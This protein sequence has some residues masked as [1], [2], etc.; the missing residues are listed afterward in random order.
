MWINDA[1]IHHANFEMKKNMYKREQKEIRMQLVRA[2]DQGVH[3]P[4]IS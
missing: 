4:I 2:I 3:S 1:N